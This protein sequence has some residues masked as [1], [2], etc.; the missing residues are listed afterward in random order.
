[1]NTYTD[2]LRNT[3]E[4]MAADAEDKGKDCF[5]ITLDF[6][7]A[8]ILID[9]L[10]RLEPTVEEDR[11]KIAP[12]YS[13]LADT[14]EGMLHPDYKERF[15]AEYQQTKIRYEKLKAFINKIEAARR[16]TC[17]PFV[18][19]AKR[20][21]EPKHDCPEEMLSNQQSIMGEYLHILEVRA[22][23]EGIEL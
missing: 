15:K 2:I 14:V 7:D 9:G 13:P 11:S 17:D 19:P 6:N 1:M 12:I 16:T 4:T 22:V 3:L 5:C 18:F 23:V 20:V 10:T 21:D 8:K